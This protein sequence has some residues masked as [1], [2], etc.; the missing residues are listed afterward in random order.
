M[1][2]LGENSLSSF[3]SGLLRVSWHITIACTIFIVTILSIILFVP[4]VTDA[5]ATGFSQANYLFFQEI[6]NDQDVVEIHSLPMI[7]KIFILP[8]I[9]TVVILLL[10][11]IRRAHR[12][13]LNLKHDII[14]DPGNVTLLRV[15]SKLVIV[16]SII[17]FSF[18]SLLLGLILFIVC[19]IFKNGTVLQEEH[20]YTV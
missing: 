8:Y 16:F 13:F 5:E 1:K 11:I 18:S 17:T 9:I 4:P 15:L 10:N 12:F 7:A 6:K 2:Y 19:E 20:D 3:L 14:F